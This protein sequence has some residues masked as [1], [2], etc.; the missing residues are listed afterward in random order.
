MELFGIVF[1]LVEIVAAVLFLICMSIATFV[2][3]ADALDESGPKWIVLIVGLAALMYFTKDLWTFSTL[4]SFLFSKEFWT[5]FAK[6]LGLGV[7]YAAIEFVFAIRTSKQQLKG[8][9]EKH[10]REKL[11]YPE[12][13]GMKPF[14][15]TTRVL[16]HQESL[17]DD[18]SIKYWAER[19]R[20]EFVCSLNSKLF[21]VRIV[22][23][24]KQIVPTVNKDYLYDNLFVWIIFWPFYAASLVLGQFL[25]DLLAAVS[26]IFVRVGDH[27]VKITFKDMFKL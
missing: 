6:Y 12:R 20:D 5:P 3:R 26:K 15:G 10:L 9:W 19:T 23:D 1:G 8:A 25:T 2:D 18:S 7:V 11:D 21:A 16:Y 17:E 13:R 24:S 22:I 4:V 27:L 14:N